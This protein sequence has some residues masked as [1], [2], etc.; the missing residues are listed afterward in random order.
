MNKTVRALCALLLVAEM[1]LHAPM[2]LAQVPPHDPGTICFTP[3][4]WCWADPPG[5]PG[6]P[7][8]CPSPYGPVEGRLG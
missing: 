5:Q 8:T 2:A 7:C 3:K 4:F 6:S 1:L